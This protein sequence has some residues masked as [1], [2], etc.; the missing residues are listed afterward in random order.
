MKEISQL[1]LNNE[2]TNKILSSGQE[3]NNQIGIEFHL[4]NFLVYELSK[5]SI[6]EIVS[7]PCSLEMSEK[8]KDDIIM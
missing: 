4:S 7:C 8:L 3:A 6:N 2:V 5:Y 1:E